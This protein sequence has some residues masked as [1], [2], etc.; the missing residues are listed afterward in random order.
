MHDEL[1]IPRQLSKAFNDAYHYFENREKIPDE[2]MAKL[3]EFDVDAK[4]FQ[5]LVT[6]KEAK[7]IYLEDGRICF[8]ELTLPPHGEIIGEVL[9]Q[10]NS[11]NVPKIFR[12]GT[13]NG[14]FPQR[15]T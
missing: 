2:I 15:N 11:Q 10:I 1:Y 4:T 6:I 5:Q 12:G 8:D 13:G 3:S 14:A 7:F 9:D